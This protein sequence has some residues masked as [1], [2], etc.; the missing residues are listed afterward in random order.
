MGELKRKMKMDMELKGLSLRTI[1]TYLSW[2]KKYTL[3]YGRSPKDLGDEEIRNYLHFLLKEKKA[4]QASITQAYSAL[5]F[6]YQTT[7]GR[8]WHGE[9][10]PRS[11]VPK[12][13]PVVLSK[14]EV[15]EIFSSTLNLKHLAIFMTIYSGGLRIS[16]A[17]HLKPEDIDSKR[18]SIKVRGKGDKERYTLLGDKTLDILRTY[19]KE[20]RPSQWLFATKLSDQP[21]STSSVQRA[22]KSSLRKAGIKKKA[23]IHTLRHSFATHLLESGV[24]LIYIQRLLGH[25]SARTTAIYL[26]VTRK[27]VARITSPIDLLED[28]DRPIQ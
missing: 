8:S 18:M 1:Q 24:D 23:S 22:F 19:W 11:K 13:L 4:A 7:L 26:H 9:K 15:Q 10:I 3:H 6:F 17:T 20:C 25:T 2:M 28:T 12:K 27:G 5:K 16:E 21:I 14:E